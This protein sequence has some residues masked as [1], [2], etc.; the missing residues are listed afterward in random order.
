VRIGRLDHVQLGIE[1]GGEE[2]A[3]EFYAG[4]LGLT[5]VEKPAALAD[6]GG[7][8]FIGDGLQ[9]HLGV[10]RPFAPSPRAHVALIADDLDA[11]RSRLAAAGIEVADD[12]SDAG[13]ARFYAR[14]PFGNRIEIVDARDADFTRR[15]PARA[16]RG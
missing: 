3:R 11:T 9:L 4:V 14:D 13:I 6:R 12:E 2:S 16:D 7:C 15:Q 8:W 10:E 5:E 1:E